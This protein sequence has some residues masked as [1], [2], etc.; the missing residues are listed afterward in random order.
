LLSVFVTFIRIKRIPILSQL[1]DVYVSFNRSVPGVLLLFI[2]YFGLPLLLS[3]IGIYINDI[4][5]IVAAILSMG[6]YHSAYLSEVFRPAYL[7]VGQGQHDAARSFGYT[8]VQKFFRIILP[9]FVP[10]ALPGY[11]NALVYLI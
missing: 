3:E 6:F 4:E 1:T 7:A 10:I 5:S 11:G 2:V 9:Q 8:P